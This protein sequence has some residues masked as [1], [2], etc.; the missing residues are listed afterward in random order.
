M[1]SDESNTEQ[2]LRSAQLEEIRLRNEKLKIELDELR[3]GKPW[4]QVP[5][6]FVPLATALVAIAGFW[7]GLVRYHDDQEK[8]HADQREQSKREQVARE[9]EF[10]KPW[11]ENQRDIYRKALSAAGTVANTENAQTRKKAA[12][13]FW[14]LYHGEM[15]LVETTSV[16]TAMV[17]FGLCLNGSEINCE[18]KKLDELAHKLGTAMSESMSATAGMTFEEFSSNQFKYK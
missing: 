5:I 4:Y 6:Q 18:K 14:S 12:E 1:A 3:K 8:A 13:E 2:T 7:W 11:L 15:I 9:R 17:N 10:M 16:S